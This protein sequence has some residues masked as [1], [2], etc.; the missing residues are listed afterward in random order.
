MQWAP[1][2]QPATAGVS[3]LPGES[4]IL[5]SGIQN[6]VDSALNVGLDTS[7][8]IARP[9]QQPLS[10]IYAPLGSHVKDKIGRGKFVDLETLLENWST[11]TKA[12]PLQ[13]SID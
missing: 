10:S 8:R 11:Q 3:A 9:N 7:S 1:A 5:L 13:V 6:I 12:D 4:G 2:V